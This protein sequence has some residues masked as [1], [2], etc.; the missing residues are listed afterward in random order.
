[1]NKRLSKQDPYAVMG[2][3]GYYYSNRNIDV[4]G[5]KITK[6]KTEHPYSYSERATWAILGKEREELL[7]NC[8]ST[9]VY[10]DRLYQWDYKKYNRITNAIWDRPQQNFCGSSPK[11]IEKMLRLYYENDD[12]ILYRIVEGCNPSNGFPYWVFGFAT[13]KNSEV[14]EEQ[15]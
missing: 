9:H 1:M 7:K 15:I 5:N 4:E 14:V 12:I 13:P 6:S 3:D 11:D 8:D 2:F 10:S